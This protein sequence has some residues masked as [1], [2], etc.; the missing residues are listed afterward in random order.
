MVKK[1]REKVSKQEKES[2]GGDEHQTELEALLEELVELEQE[3]EKAADT[4]DQAK[5][6]AAEQDEKKANE[7]RERALEQ[8][9]QTR[10]RNGETEKEEDRKETKRRRSGGEAIEWL[11][12]KEEIVKQMKE[13]EVHEKREERERHKD[14]SIS[15]LW[16]SF[17]QPK[18]LKMS[19]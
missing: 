12:E 5:K 6:T 1:W 8:F 14:F 11:K 4:Q 19:S 13:Q 7:M 18:P 2:G 3:S 17:M 9:G 10:K 15:N 16:S